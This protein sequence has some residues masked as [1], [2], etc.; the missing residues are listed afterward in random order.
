[1]QCFMCDVHLQVDVN[2]G[3]KSSAQSFIHKT[4]FKTVDSDYISMEIQPLESFQ[5]EKFKRLNYHWYFRN[6]FLC[7]YTHDNKRILNLNLIW[8]C[9]V[10]NSFKGESGNDKRSIT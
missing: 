2:S 9:A 10:G 6:K 8:F 5:K 7:V 1:M 3:Q 4:H